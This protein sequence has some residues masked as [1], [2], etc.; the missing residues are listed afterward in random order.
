MSWSYTAELPQGALVK[1]R[2]H[3]DLTSI[4]FQDKSIPLAAIET[5]KV[6]ITRQSVNGIPTATT[7]QV[8]LGSSQVP[9]LKM[10]WAFASLQSKETK[11]RCEEAYQILMN[12]LDGE[13]RDR[14]VQAQLSRPLPTKFGPFEIS[15]Q[16]VTARALIKTVEVPWQSVAGTNLAAG[17]YSLVYIN[18]KGKQANLGAMDLW[19]DNALW[20]PQIIA[21]YRQWFAGAP[22]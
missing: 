17:V 6:R 15:P 21:G 22:G 1:R 13:V 5:V 12:V 7:Y 16:N 9:T 14:V 8:E 19:Q 2:V 11:A 4:N 20:L 18:D 3:Y 10:N